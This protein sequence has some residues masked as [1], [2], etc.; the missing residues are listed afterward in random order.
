MWE[1]W[2]AWAAWRLEAAAMERTLA[3]RCSHQVVRLEL[4]QKAHSSSVALIMTRK[5]RFVSPFSDSGLR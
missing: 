5:K 3:L 4:L 2:L 1:G